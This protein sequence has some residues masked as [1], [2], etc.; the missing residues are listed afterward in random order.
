MRPGVLVCALAAA[1]LVFGTADVVA[2]SSSVAPEVDGSVTG[3]HLSSSAIRAALTSV[4]G[5]LKPGNVAPNEQRIGELPFTFVAAPFDVRIL[6]AGDKI[7][8]YNPT[9]NV[10]LVDDGLHDAEGV[11]MYSYQGQ[12]WNHVS[13]QARYGLANVN[14]FRATGNADYLVRAEAQAKRL[15]ERSVDR[16]GAWFH[17]YD[18]V[19]YEM[20]PPLWFIAQPPWYSAL[21][22]GYA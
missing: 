11:R 4:A 22:Q 18:F 8:F 14:A 19:W 16:E 21:G 7:L 2:A 9:P 12:L 17:P 3:V 5:E 1:F 10:P 6:P 13:A 15:I 20:H